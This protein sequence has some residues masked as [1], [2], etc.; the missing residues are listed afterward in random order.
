MPIEFIMLAA[1][2]MASVVGACSASA[3][4][5]TN[6]HLA[7]AMAAEL[8]VLAAAEHC[9]YYFESSIFNRLY[10]SSVGRLDFIHFLNFYL[11]D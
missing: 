8:E 3:R 2:I 11:V 1:L 7:E 6:L 9:K 5:G 10:F 4:A